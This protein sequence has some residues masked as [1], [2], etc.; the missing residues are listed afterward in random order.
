MLGLELLP[1]ARPPVPPLVPP[2]ELLCLLVVL[3]LPPKLPL[4]F[5]FAS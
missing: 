1:S 5:S 4:L 2:A 3:L